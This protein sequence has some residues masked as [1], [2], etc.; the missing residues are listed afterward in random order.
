MTT[1]AREGSVFFAVLM[2]AGLG[3]AVN[4]VDQP[5][6]IN[7]AMLA[8]ADLAGAAGGDAFAAILHCILEGAQ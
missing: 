8:Q 6:I 1:P 2:D 4:Q 5:V 3:D 7:A